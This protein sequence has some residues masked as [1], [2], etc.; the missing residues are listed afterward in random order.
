MKQYAVGGPLIS[1]YDPNLPTPGNVANINITIYADSEQP[2]GYTPPVIY[3]YMPVYPL[4]FAATDYATPT[5]LNGCSI[6]FTFN[7]GTVVL[8]PDS[9]ISLDIYLGNNTWTTVTVSGSLWQQWNISQGT[10][11]PT[12][13][14]PART[15]RLPTGTMQINNLPVSADGV[16]WYRI[17]VAS[18]DGSDEKIFNLYTTTSGGQFISGPGSLAIDGLANVVTRRTA[19]RRS[20]H[21]RSTS[22]TGVTSSIA[23]ELLVW[24]TDTTLVGHL[25]PPNAV[26]AGTFGSPTSPTPGVVDRPRFSDRTTQVAGNTTTRA[27]DSG[28][29]A[30]GWTGLNNSVRH[31]V[32]DF[33]YTN[34]TSA[35]NVAKI[36]SIAPGGGKTPN[37]FVT[38]IADLDGQ[39]LTPK[40]NSS[41]TAAIR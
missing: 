10:A 41:A 23:P 36:D 39:W 7:N 11:G 27:N 5:V 34:K 2:G 32:V 12:R 37:I 28:E 14:R 1:V 19:P 15:S 3:N 16:G 33:R 26:V 8:D 6:Q 25:Q 24:N 40:G 22:L 20:R 13:S 21:S 9:K 31:D 35:T 4:D 30:F 18:S 17:H 29:I 38:T